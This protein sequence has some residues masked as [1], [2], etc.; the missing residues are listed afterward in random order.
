LSCCPFPF[1][2]CIVCFVDCCLSFC[3]FP[4]NLQNRQYNGQKEMDNKTNNNLQNR[5][6]NGQKE[7]DKKTN[8][9][10]QNRQILPIKRHILPIYSTDDTLL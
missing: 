4:N 7:M 10:L 1:G 3:P 9:N 8:N 2:H 5:Q 6:Y